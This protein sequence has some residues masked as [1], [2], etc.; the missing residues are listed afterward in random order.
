VT[1]GIDPRSAL[2]AIWGS[3]KND[4]WAVGSRGTIL[5]WDGA[6]WV[7]TPSGTNQTFLAVSG[8]GPNDVWAV[9]S[10]A[11]LLHSTGFAGSTS[12]AA[13]PPVAPSYCQYCP[14]LWNE[15]LL[16]TVWAPAGDKVWIGS[17]P[18]PVLP[19]A[20]PPATQ[21]N[22]WRRSGSSDSAWDYNVVANNVVV[23]GLWGSPGDLWAVGG[24]AGNGTKR[25]GRAFHTTD[26]TDGKAPAW[27][28]IDTQSSVDLRAV[29]GAGSNDVWAVG[30]EGTVRHWTN[31]TPK[32]WDIVSVPTTSDLRAVWGSGPN[33]VW[34]AGDF[35]TILH[36]D[37][38][39]WTPAVAAFPQGLK[40][41]LRGIWGSSADDVWIVGDS[42]VLHFT[43]KAGN[44]P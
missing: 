31:A 13:V 11:V 4:V 25:A 28:E 17:E 18:Y 39:S 26:S 3:G 8:S 41:H 36:F 38:A 15:S 44:A 35:G 43:G 19:E 1:I 30:D 10:R 2:T 22:L 16:L 42:V 5:H 23:R 6:S 29:W 20:G 37:G 33:D 9:S 24:I 7:S 14:E 27:T 12:W 21:M 40:P 32:R 34:V